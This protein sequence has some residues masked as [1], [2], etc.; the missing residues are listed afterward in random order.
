VGLAA[1][2]LGDQVDPRRGADDLARQ[3]PEHLHRELP[4]GLCEVGAGEE[5][6]GI[7][8]VEGSPAVYHLV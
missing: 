1:A 7:P 3:T 8:V 2:E 6:L 4:I 5:A